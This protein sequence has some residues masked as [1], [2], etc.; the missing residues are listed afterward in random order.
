MN[1]KHAS[2]SKSHSKSKS[3][4]PGLVEKG[5]FVPPY[6]MLPRGPKPK[7][8]IES[9]DEIFGTQKGSPNRVFSAVA[10]K[11]VHK[12][13]FSN[14]DS[15]SSGVRRENPSHYPLSDEMSE[16]SINQ[17][18]SNS[19]THIDEYSHKRV[20]SAS[21]SSKAKNVSLPKNLDAV[22][23]DNLETTQEVAQSKTQNLEEFAFKQKCKSL[24]FSTKAS[25]PKMES[26]ANLLL[27]GLNYLLL[28][29]DKSM[30]KERPSPPVSVRQPRPAR[31]LMLE[32]FHVICLA[33][34][35]VDGRLAIHHRPYA[36][37]L[38]RQAAKDWQIVLYSTRPLAAV[39]QVRDSFDP[40]DILGMMAVGQESC[41]DL[42]DGRKTKEIEIVEGATQKN[43]VMVDYKLHNMVLNPLNAV[44][45]MNW[46][47][48]SQDDELKGLL[49]YLET[50]SSE[51]DLALS[52]SS[53]LNYLSLLS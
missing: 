1:R 26:F 35:G 42:T 39:W 52:N 45:V 5:S 10:P 20:V 22:L 31:Y 14:F 48:G 40:D 12:P 27:S 4:S 16:L 49:S 37:Q 43:T 23:E 30:V 44:I 47:G 46:E 3:R 15:S 50:I 25:P 11:K 8:E 13:R 32:C 17:E 29:D 28:F 18:Q 19:R 36:H 41:V 2:V 34:A 51:E 38:L 33:A 7:F 21:F 24:V 9:T 53:A 6:A